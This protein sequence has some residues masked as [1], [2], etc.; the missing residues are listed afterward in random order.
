MGTAAQVR[1]EDRPL[2]P[3]EIEILADLVIDEPDHYTVLGVVRASPMSEINTAY[4]RAVDFFHPLNYSHLAQSNNVLHWKLS[5]AY[6]R[7]VKAFST[8][9][10]RA[11][12]QVYDGTLNRQIVGSIRTQQRLA[13]Q[14]DRA[15]AVAT[16]RTAQASVEKRPLQPN[17]RER[18]RVER[19]ALRLPLVVVFDHNWQ[20]ITETID[21][22]PLGAKFVLSHPVEPGTL[23]RL[24]LP[25]PPDM[26]TR[27]DTSVLY[28]IDGYVIQVTLD[29]GQRVVVAEFL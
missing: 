25:M 26:R 4:C 3:D 9:S 2:T 28:T 12:R 21:V 20:E 29:P 1:F 17:N 23:L 24:E 22:S 10:S 8:L 11:R 27:A 15:N 6:L 7:I 19:V 13:S 18:R 16:G 5:C 14:A